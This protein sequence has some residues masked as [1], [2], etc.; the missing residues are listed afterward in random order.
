SISS[1][2]STST[3]RCAGRAKAPG[4]SAAATRGA[5]VASIHPERGG[6]RAC[7]CPPALPL[8]GASMARMASVPLR[9]G[10]GAAETTGEM[11]AGTGGHGGKRAISASLNYNHR[12]EEADQV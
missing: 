3:V 12:G 1:S 5:A 2:P 9:W 11:L 8:A 4:A 7:V 6:R 10:G